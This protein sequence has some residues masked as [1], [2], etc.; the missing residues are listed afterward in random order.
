MRAAHS[1]LRMVQAGCPWFKLA[2]HGLDG[3]MLHWVKHW[4]DGQA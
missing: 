2:A 1:W 3:H 4:L